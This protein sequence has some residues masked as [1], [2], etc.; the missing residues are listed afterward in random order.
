MNWSENHIF[1]LIMDVSKRTRT[2]NWHKIR[3]RHWLSLLNPTVHFHC[4][5]LALEN[6]YIWMLPAWR[7]YAYRKRSLLRQ[8]AVRFSV[9]DLHLQIWTVLGKSSASQLLPIVITPVSRCVYV[10]IYLCIYSS[11]SY[12]FGELNYEKNQRYTTYAI[13]RRKSCFST[14][15]PL[16][17]L[18]RSK[19]EN[20]INA[21]SREK[22]YPYDFYVSWYLSSN[23]ISP[24][25]V[26]LLRDVDLCFQR[27]KV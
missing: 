24:V 26:F 11:F 3:Q 7:S 25:P 4:F 5:P 21:K 12:V 8:V 13:E 9:T 2:M 20:I 14:T 19:L 16:T 18:S 6:G 23:G 1:G 15:W 10:C 27:S 17:K 22:N